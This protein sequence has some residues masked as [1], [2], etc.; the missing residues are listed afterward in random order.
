MPNAS[1]FGF[2]IE[3]Q[4]P[5][6]KTKAEATARPWRITSQEYGG[7]SGAAIEGVVPVI[8]MQGAC[9]ALIVSMGADKAEQDATA[10]LIVRAV[11]AHEAMREALANSLDALT[12]LRGYFD[13]ESHEYDTIDHEIKRTIAALNLAGE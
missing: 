8:R 3:G 13:A 5:S 4:L 10:A 12:G 1:D 7:S 6:T 11:N 9:K 2:S